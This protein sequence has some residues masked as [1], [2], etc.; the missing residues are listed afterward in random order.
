MSLSA[1]P[2][3]DLLVQQ[4]ALNFAFGVVQMIDNSY[5]NPRLIEDI[6]EA[7]GA[8]F[9]KDVDL[10]AAGFGII[11]VTL[12]LVAHINDKPL[13]FADPRRNEIR[14]F[15]FPTDIKGSVE[16][17]GLVEVRDG[18]LRLL[19]EN[20]D[21]IHR[22]VFHEFI[23][24]L[25]FHRSQ[26]VPQASGYHDEEG[27]IVPKKYARDPY[28]FNAMFQTV[29]AETGMLLARLREEKPRTYRNVVR[30]FFRLV[31]FVKENDES[32]AFEL[33]LRYNEKRTLS[34]LY[35]IWER[36]REAERHEPEGFVK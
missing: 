33:L 2:D 17:H 32:G 4:V 26:R 6:S 5:D 24:L 1:Q 31:R 9:K 13:A 22:A 8:I 11:P 29:V 28:E 3:R 23:H 19:H 35:Q 12:V 36:L 21:D 27:A 15:I 7:G 34:R 10:N 25:D 20:S 14:L 18:M 30:N 16:I